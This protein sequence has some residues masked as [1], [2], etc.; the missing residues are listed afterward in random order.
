LRVLVP[1]SSCI[2]TPTSSRTLEIHCRQSSPTPR[3][4]S[5]HHR[6]VP[7]ELYPITAPKL[8][9]EF[10]P[11]TAIEI[12]LSNTP[13]APEL[14]HQPLSRSC[15]PMWHGSIGR[16]G[17]GEGATSR[18]FRGVQRGI[19][20]WARFGESVG[21]VNSD[22]FPILG[23]VHYGGQELLGRPYMVTYGV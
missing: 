6:R 21:G 14:R 11:V 1:G 23:W 9:A 16:N 19:G 3:A 12:H 22:Y 20:G 18:W 17:M 13:A 8:R 7:H 4:P 5:S 2:V 15:A 10:H